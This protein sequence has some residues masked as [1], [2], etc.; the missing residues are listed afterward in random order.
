[1]YSGSQQVDYLNTK[2]SSDG[3]LS[4]YLVMRLVTTFAY[5]LHDNTLFFN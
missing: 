2:D 1:M 5:T 4:H 3:F